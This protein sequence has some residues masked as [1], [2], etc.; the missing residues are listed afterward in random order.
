MFEFK[1]WPCSTTMEFTSTNRQRDRI[2]TLR[3]SHCLLQRLSKANIIGL[4]WLDVTRVEIPPGAYLEMV[5]YRPTT[6]QTTEA[7]SK[8]SE[9][10]YAGIQVVA[11]VIV[12]TSYKKISGTD[13]TLLDVAFDVRL[14]T[15][16]KGDEFNFKVSTSLEAETLLNRG[17]GF[18]NRE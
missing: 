6:T 2:Q 18:L 15:V 13:P 7:N 1:A 12:L 8:T 17:L 11:I 9:P 16:A 3:S 14:G 10:T 5:H 4:R